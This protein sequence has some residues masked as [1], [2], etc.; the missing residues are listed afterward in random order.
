MLS[1]FTYSACAQLV[2]HLKN[3]VELI[4]GSS[5][6]HDYFQQLIINV[7]DKQESAQTQVKIW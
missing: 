3:T 7:F 1:P 2:N 6:V 5:A 4:S